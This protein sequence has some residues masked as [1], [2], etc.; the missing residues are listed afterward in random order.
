MGRCIAEAR[1]RYGQFERLQEPA[2]LHQFFGD[3]AVVE[4]SAREE[5]A[6]EMF[7]KYVIAHFRNRVPRV[8]ASAAAAAAIYA[9]GS[10]YQTQETF[11]EWLERPPSL[12]LTTPLQYSRFVLSR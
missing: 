7:R 10:A 2:Q 1:Q 3:D 4:D 6:I 9:G 5:D 12:N 11:R 8:E